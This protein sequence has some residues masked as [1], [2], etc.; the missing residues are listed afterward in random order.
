MAA[1]VHPGK[2]A[3]G[4]G[5]RWDGSQAVSAVA[6][7]A[8]TATVLASAEIDWPPAIAATRDGRA[9]VVWVERVENTETLVGSRYDGKT[10]SSPF[11]IAGPAGTL[12]APA[13]AASADGSGWVAW[14]EYVGAEARLRAA[15]VTVSGH[16]GAVLDVAEAADDG[17]GVYARALAPAAGL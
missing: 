7:G 2:C 12:L 1:V 13:I 6:P 14:Q 15:T 8:H 5:D 4:P 16:V 10:W 11:S 9:I 3:P 17:H